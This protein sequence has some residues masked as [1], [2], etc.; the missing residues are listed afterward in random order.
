[1]KPFAD[2]FSE[3]SGHYM[4]FRP[5]YPIEFIKEIAMLSKEQ[6][7]CWDC[8][9]GNGQVA[10]EL[11]RYFNKVYATD[12]SENQISQAIPAKNIVYEISRAEKTSFPS[13]NFDLITVAQAIHWFDLSLFYEEAKRVAKPDGILAVWGYGLLRFHNKIDR[14]LDQFYHEVVGPFRDKE[15]QHIE[16]AYST[17]SFPF[18]QV[19]LSRQYFIQKEFTLEEFAGYLSTWSSVKRFKKEK[20][21]DPVEQFIGTIHQEWERNGLKLNA[22]FPLFTKIGRIK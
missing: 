4:K 18:E 3:N 22:E 17:I 12:I 21:S 1:M 5:Q 15:R 13:D 8:G 10:S 2:R 7:K 14:A 11:A 6:T 9:T 16:A 20:R 19:P